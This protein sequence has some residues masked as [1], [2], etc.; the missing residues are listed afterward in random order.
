MTGAV[1]V[2]G[3]IWDE[4]RT[5]GQGQAKRWRKSRRGKD[6]REEF[7]GGDMVTEGGS[8]GRNTIER[9]RDEEEVRVGR[10]R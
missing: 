9:R 10:R 3:S 6:V 4:G 8:L 1:R 2:L 7:P 5:D